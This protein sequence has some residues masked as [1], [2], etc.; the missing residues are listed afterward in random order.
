MRMFLRSLD[1]IDLTPGAGVRKLEQWVIDVTQARRRI[2]RDLTGRMDDAANVPEVTTE[3]FFDM[4]EEQTRN[5]IVCASNTLYATPGAHDENLSPMLQANYNDAFSES[6][7]I[8]R[9]IKRYLTDEKFFRRIERWGVEMNLVCDEFHD[10]TP[11]GAFMHRVIDQQNEAIAS[12]SIGIGMTQADF[13]MYRRQRVQ[14]A[15]QLKTL[16]GKEAHRLSESQ[17]QYGVKAPLVP[18]IRD[19]SRTA[20]YRKEC[21]IKKWKKELESTKS[22]GA[23]KIAPK[24]TTVPPYLD[25][26]PL[27][28]LDAWVPKNKWKA[29]AKGDWVETEYRARLRV[30]EPRESDRKWQQM[31]DNGTEASRSGEDHKPRWDG[32]KLVWYVTHSLHVDDYRRWQLSVREW[33]AEMERMKTLIDIHVDGP[34]SSDPEYERL[35][36]ANGFDSLSVREWEQFEVDDEH[37]NRNRR[38]LAVKRTQIRRARAGLLK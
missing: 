30:D 33:E 17:L 19:K 35:L 2:W 7:F 29:N 31:A 18:A 5:D 4:V 12:A 34:D 23:Y 13:K 16:D 8:Y 28:I 1:D 26:E 21:T 10:H 9:L 11:V 15:R 38:A 14:G 27:D 6:I 22:R 36:V 37:E 32:R 20:M 25:D 3:Q 24:Y